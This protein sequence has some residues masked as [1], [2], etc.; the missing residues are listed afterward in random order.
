MK[1]QVLGV[2]RLAGIAKESGNPFEM[3]TLLAVVPI[4]Q[5]SGKNFSVQGYGYEVGEM[6]VDPD[7]LKQFENHKYPCVMD[8]TTETVMGRNNKLSQIVTGTT[9]Q[10]AVKSV[11]NG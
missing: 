11:S 2:K 3:C 9:T 7:A 6:D 8:L 1:I 10:P 5:V 4:E